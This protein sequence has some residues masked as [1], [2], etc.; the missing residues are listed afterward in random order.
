ML[1]LLP[2]RSCWDR[3]DADVM[4]RIEALGVDDTLFLATHTPIRGFGVGGAKRQ[5]LDEPT[6]AALLDA[7]SNPNR[8]HAFCVVQGDPG[9]GKSHLIR[10]LAVHWP[11]GDDIVLLLQ[12][13][14]GSLQGA[15]EQLKTSL[16]VKWPEFEP[17][18]ENL[19]RRRQTA[20]IAGRAEVFQSTLGAMLKGSFF[21]ERRA[22]AEWCDKHDLSLL[23]QSLP[24]RQGWKSPRRILE[25]MDGKS[26]ARNSESAQFN[27][28][29]IVSL[30]RVCVEVHDSV[31]S[32]RFA[33]Q[34]VVEAEKI[35]GWTDAG[36][37][38]EEIRA[39]H[40][41]DLPASLPLLR[42]LNSRLNDAV[43][44]VIGV[45][46][47]DLILLFRKVR[48]ALKGRARL[49]LLLEDITAWQGLD[50]GLIDAL[51]LD[52]A[53]RP[54]VCPL[55][56]VVGVTPDYYDPLQKNYR[57]RIT[58]E[59]Q[60][61][62]PSG[63]ESA[64]LRE[65]A[66]RL[67]FVARYLNATRA[68]QAKLMAWRPA[69]MSAR[70]TPPPNPCLD[71]PKRPGCHAVFGEVD[72]MGLFPF[73]P[74]ALDVLFHALKTDDKGQTHRT[75]RGLLQNVLGPTLRNPAMLDDGRYPGPD[76]E[77]EK[78]DERA[79]L[80][81]GPMRALVDAN[82]ADIET[83][84][85]L[86]RTFV[87][88]GDP[89]RPDTTSDS[90][91][92]TRLAEVRREVFTSFR[93]PW[94]GDTD[95][96]PR[97]LEPPSE[98]T[99]AA[100]PATGAA[101]QTAQPAPAAPA[102]GPEATPVTATSPS[103]TRAPSTATPTTTRPTTTTKT[104]LQRLQSHISEARSGTAP[105]KDAPLWNEVLFEVMRA[106]DPRSL[107]LDRW[108]W[109]TLF[110]SSTVLVAG[111]SQ[112]RNYTFAVPRDAWL[113]DGLEAYCAL[114]GGG[115]PDSSQEYYR[116]RLA[117]MVRRLGALAKAHAARRT[118][119]LPDGAAW[120]MAATATQV[121]LARAWLKGAVS[122]TAATSEQWRVLLSG[123]DGT[124]T[125]PQ[126][127]TEPWQDALRNTDQ[128]HDK[129]RTL[130]REMITLPQGQ[131]LEFGLAAAGSA[132]QAV[133]RLQ[134]R[135]SFLPYSEAAET[136]SL[137][138][139]RGLRQTAAKMADYVR[140][141]PALETR[142]L[143]ERAA[144]VATLLRGESLA[145]RMRRIH[146]AAGKVFPLIRELPPELERRWRET[147]E[148]LEADLSRPD[149]LGPL[150]RLIVSVEDSE[151]IPKE[152]AA[153]LAWLVAQPAGDLRSAGEALKQGDQLCKALS[154]R[155]APYLRS[156]GAGAT[157]AQIK[158]AGESL[159]AVA[160]E[161]KTTW[162]GGQ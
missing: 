160:V 76:I 64:T 90:D 54:D 60:L 102:P 92:V 150:Q 12:R 145:A 154:E 136:S 4:L 130:L 111:S 124:A 128:Q 105:L 59:I 77:T 135:L 113:Y 75:P 25:L 161:A 97:T 2:S 3:D 89:T 109:N 39:S 117:F 100:A 40:A 116:R 101:D 93:L 81:N 61:G 127:R 107:G 27:L 122:P 83:R 66:D 108:T 62:Q 14:D 110:T 94:L 9:S 98:T 5:D 125:S 142:L 149:Y 37:T 13:A 156:A 79:G 18:F 43:Q 104:K 157:L 134:R 38:H 10:W 46:G 48:T 137:L 114:R 162:E 151:A 65:G 91:G 15:L 132:A 36:E 1:E 44:S 144:E 106:I 56:S 23:I 47:E 115:Q 52:A 68:G 99:E 80:L 51:V 31:A 141:I 49:V 22:D 152:T 33:R 58:H 133:V 148:R 57:D 147:W 6:E 158:S 118:P 8:T 50:N 86:R 63:A 78:L 88:W 41:D 126:S 17:L 84:E 72:S 24:V 131:S 7:L 73:T 146:T 20:G 70:D 34:L 120:D 139:D 71:C 67:A 16:T 26:S 143:Q 87:Y 119:S 138:D 69:A 96:T 30:G 112:S 45:T 82:E 11:A 29:D 123:E 19:D 28:D 53:T 55:I 103:I 74:H 32:E 95:P 42:T 159:E 140:R 129:I 21:E 35:R 153:L 155:A 85:R 121:L